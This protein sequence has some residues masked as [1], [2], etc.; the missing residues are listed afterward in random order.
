MGCCPSQLA[1]AHD[2]SNPKGID[3][4]GC[5]AALN[6]LSGQLYPMFDAMLQGLSQELP[7]MNYSLVNSIKMAE[8]VFESPATPTYSNNR[9]QAQLLP[10]P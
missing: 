5:F 2:P 9:H 3:K 10:I 6:N 4:Y 1:I 8:W 7:G